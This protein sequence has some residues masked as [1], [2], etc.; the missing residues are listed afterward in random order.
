MGTPSLPPSPAYSNSSSEPKLS[1]RAALDEL[2]RRADHG[3]AM[4]DAIRRAWCIVFTPAVLSLACLEPNPNAVDA[5]GETDASASM[6]N[7]DGDGDGEPPPICEPCDLGFEMVTFEAGPDGF[8]GQVPKPPQSNSVPLGLV[9]EYVPGNSSNLGYAISWAEAGDAWEFTVEL[10]GA[11]N[12][13]RV[14]GVAAVLASNSDL[15]VETAAV[16]GADGC[17]GATID[18][19]GGR[20]VVDVLERYSP[21]DDLVLNYARESSSTGDSATVDYCVTAS[22]TPEASLGFKLVAFD[23][24]EGVTAL[25]ISDITL[26]SGA[27]QS[28]SYDQIASNAE[29]LHVIGAREFDETA[30]ND[31][32][33]GIDC[34]SSAPFGCSF[35]LQGYSGGARA[36]VGGVIVAIQ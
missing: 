22:D 26:D 23:L 2:A 10:T 4:H 6:T 8:V 1:S 7:G 3:S 31:L 17:L 11:A 16:T 14:R 9:R 15:S 5:G 25:E 18:G 29:V 19:L 28:A 32:G 24:P 30:A 33:Y 12:N 35:D 13:S 36:V 20:A 21:G 27:P 34:S